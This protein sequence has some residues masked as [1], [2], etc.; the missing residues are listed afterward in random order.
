M[1]APPAHFNLTEA[2]DRVDGDRELLQEMAALLLD[3]IPCQLQSITEAVE[4]DD[5]DAVARAAHSLKGAV[6]SLAAHSTQEAAS[7]AEAS[8]LKHDSRQLALDVRKIK[9]EVARLLPELHR[10]CEG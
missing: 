4:A 8:A 9:A 6:A 5:L 7:Q 10:I 2:L 3:D 1:P